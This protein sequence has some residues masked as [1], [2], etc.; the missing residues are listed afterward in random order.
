MKCAIFTEGGISSGFGH[1]TRCLSLSQ[2][3]KKEGISCKL[4]INGD[5]TVEKLLAGEEYI[6][7]DWIGD[8]KETDLEL[9]ESDIAVI[10]SYLAE[11]VFYDKVASKVKVPVFIDDNKRFDYP[12]GIVINGNIYAPELDYT[13]EKE[14][15]YLLGLE[16]APMR[17]A[18]WGSSEKKVRH[19]VKEVI[20]TFGGN[21]SENMTALF[22]S[23]LNK[24]F[25]TLKKK[26]LLGRTFE[27][28]NEIETLYSEN[29]E[30][31]FNPDEK[32]MRAIMEEA[33]IAFSGGGQ[34]LAEL[35][36]VGVPTLAVCVA[37]NQV[38]NVKAWQSTGF[39]EYLMAGGEEEFA[40]KVE[41]FIKRHRDASTREEKSDIGKKLVDGK[42][43]VN[44]LDEVIS[45]GEKR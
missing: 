39:L 43:A 7:T 6:L 32:E 33:D 15:K 35:A 1:I 27:K 11:P 30:L 29:T 10:D 44:I 37:D 8:Q 24:L 17:K 20:I 5:E 45:Y 2:A 14:S 25:P 22:V 41:D 19:E 9:E 3:F 42:G 13:E 28:S 18:F 31:I 12:R 16:Y 21:D 38:R 26:V 4:M 36:H 23:L 34:T 40:S